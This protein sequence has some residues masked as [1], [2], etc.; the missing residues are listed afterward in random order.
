MTHHDTPSIIAIDGPAASGKSTLGRRLA[1]AL[2]YMFFD[3]GAMYRAL[4]W[5]ALER[6]L[7]PRDEQAISELARA[8]KIDVLP[9]SKDDGRSVDVLMDGKDVTWEIRRRKIDA[10]VSVVAAY[11]GVRTA[12]SQLA[13]MLTALAVW[14]ILCRSGPPQGVDVTRRDLLLAAA[15]AGLTVTFY[16]VIKAYTLGQIQTWINALFAFVVLACMSGR[17]RAAG[18]LLGLVLLM[19]PTYWPLVLWGILRRQPG[20]VVAALAT[21]LTGSLLA[22]REFGWSDSIAYGQALGYVAERGEVFYPNQSFNGLLN[23][24]F[25]AADSLRFTRSAFAPYHPWVYALTVAA[26]LGAMALALIVPARRRAAG[27]VIDLGIMALSV[28]LTSP[29]AWDHHY[30]VLLPIIAATAPAIL[31]PAVLGR[32]TTPALVGVYVIASQSFIVTNRFAGTWL[33]VLQS[34][35]FFAACLYLLF[36]YLAAARDSRDVT[37]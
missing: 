16:P 32:W 26:F 33:F 11:P 15:V 36:L 20:F 7:D 14:L 25:G 30:G 23:R 19:K 35:L 18:V 6:G 12:L 28:T 21:L 9:P 34:Y 10:N 22:A 37:T 3:T 5:L 4:A 2:G 31:R 24:W 13:V 17:R 27:G 8:A 29:I 1:D